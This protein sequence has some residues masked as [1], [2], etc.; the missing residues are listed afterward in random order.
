MSYNVYLNEFEDPPLI[1]ENNAIEK[2][3]RPA[4]IELLGGDLGFYSIISIVKNNTPHRWWSWE[5]K[6]IGPS[7]LFGITT[8]KWIGRIAEDPVKAIVEESKLSDSFSK[9]MPSAGGRRRRSRRRT[10]SSRK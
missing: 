2:L 7:K 9:F 3:E 6:R 10:H 5:A 4:I 8:I 1:I